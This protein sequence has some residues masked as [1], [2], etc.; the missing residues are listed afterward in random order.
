MDASENKRWSGLFLTGVS[1]LAL[2]VIFNAWLA[3]GPFPA[4][5][6][7]VL[8]SASL[9]CWVGYRSFDEE[10]ITVNFWQILPQVGFIGTALWLGN[11]PYFE[12]SETV[13]AVLQIR[14]TSDGE[15]LPDLLVTIERNDGQIIRKSKTGENGDCVFKINGQK[16][17]AV[18]VFSTWTSHQSPGSL[19]TLTGIDGSWTSIPLGVLTG[20]PLP[21]S[22]YTIEARIS[23]T[24]E[25]PEASSG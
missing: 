23:E 12:Y 10:K 4:F 1:V 13:P 15:P 18:A 9:M 14:L 3:A 22:T 21:E 17:T 20:Q 2:V 25:L 16:T 6:L 7:A 19:W 8:S 24:S 11:L 5:C